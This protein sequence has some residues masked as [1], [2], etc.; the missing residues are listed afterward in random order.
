M[1]NFLDHSTIFL[2]LASSVETPMALSTSKGK[3]TRSA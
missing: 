2:W 1:Y 3:T